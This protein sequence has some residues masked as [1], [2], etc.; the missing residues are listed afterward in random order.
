MIHNGLVR[1]VVYSVFCL[2]PLSAVAQLD[3][4][5]KAQL[6]GIQVDEK[7]GATDKEK[8]TDVSF[9]FT[10]K[11]RQ[12]FHTLKENVLTLEFYDAQPGEDKLP[13]IKQAPF[14]GCT[15]ATDKVDVNK[16]IEGMEPLLK[17]IVRVTLPLQ[18]GVTIDYTLSDDFNVITHA[19]VWSKEGAIKNLKTQ[20]KSKAWMYIAGGIVG[21]TAGTVA[22]LFFKAPSDTGQV[23]KGPGPWD[24]AP[25]GL[26]GGGQ[27]PQ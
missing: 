7:P 20:K 5:E 17:D 13:A 27:P 16:D 23:K 21:V 2:L 4:K 24:P 19:T 10:G 25:P 14:A 9:I 26:P 12:Y 6:V 22:Y 18:A 15:I 8:L 11:P 3:L 1:A